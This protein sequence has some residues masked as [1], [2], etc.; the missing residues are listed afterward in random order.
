MSGAIKFTKGIQYKR[1]VMQPI[2]NSCRPFFS[3]NFLISEVSATSVKTS[4]VKTRELNQLI[5][6]KG[7]TMAANGIN[8]SGIE[9]N[10]DRKYLI[11]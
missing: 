10:Q 8:Q 6:R 7:I 3:M 11:E 4:K 9:P 5:R 2:K 1:L